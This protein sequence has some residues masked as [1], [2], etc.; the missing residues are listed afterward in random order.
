MPDVISS[1]TYGTDLPPYDSG[2]D[3]RDSIRFKLPVFEGPL[4]L[5]LHL[6]RTNKID[7]YDIPILQITRQYLE[8]LEL[9]KDLNLEIAGD[10]L[11]MAA[12]L[13]HI[14]SRTLLPPAEEEM[15]EAVEDPRAELVQRLLEYQK[16]REV[17][18]QLRKREELW[19]S[20]FHRRLSE[21]DE[22]DIDTEPVLFDVSV[23]DLISAFKT[24][25][26]KAPEQVI[27]ITRETL[28]VSDRIHV[29]MERLEKED[30][31][32][33]LELFEDGYTRVS[34]IVTF[35]ALLELN[36][37][38][39]ARAYQEKTF[40]VIWILNPQKAEAILAQTLGSS[41][42]NIPTEEH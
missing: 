17:S 16:F 35:L 8:Y 25:L 15:D 20:V 29:I 9:M 32:R 1:D 11:V 14:K 38:G 27:E 36:R 4:D 31:I 21:M 19:K 39:L 23:F 26:I 41:S 10:F 5:L 33:F 28:T 2:S 3:S 37:L 7:I 13:I 18:G 34:L 22:I 6:I 40:G 12:T 30:G 24:I 42:E